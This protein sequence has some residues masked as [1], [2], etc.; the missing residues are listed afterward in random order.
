MKKA[1]NEFFLCSYHPSLQK[2]N[3]IHFTHREIDVLA[4]LVSARQ[5]KVIASSLSVSLKT[6]DN[7][8]RNIRDKINCNATDGVITFCEN[9]GVDGLLRTHYVNL[10]N[11]VAFKQS[12][13]QIAAMH[14]REANISCTIICFQKQQLEDP[15]LLQLESHLKLAGITVSL[16]TQEPQ[17]TRPTH[18]N[19]FSLYII[20]KSFLAS[21][22]KMVVPQSNNKMLFLLPES[23]NLTETYKDLPYVSYHNL[24]EP[25]QYYELFFE[26]VRKIFPS[27]DWK[28]F[29]PQFKESNENGKIHLIPLISSSNLDKKKSAVKEKNEF[30]KFSILNNKIL[31]FSFFVTI[32]LICGAVFL[33]HFTDSQNQRSFIRS[34]L[35]IPVES[36]LL[37]RSKLMAQID[38]TLSN[39]QRGIKAIAIVGIGGAGK[40]TLAHQYA[41]KKNA[42]VIWKINA[43]TKESLKA[44]FEELAQHLARTEEY[45][46]TLR[47]IQDVKKTGEKE[48]KILLFVQD[49]LR[50]YPNWLLIY[51]NVEQFIDIQKYF[52]QDIKLWGE[53]KVILT[54]KNS[55]IQNN[56]LI[57]NV[58]HIGELSPEQK[59]NLFTKITVHGSSR[60]VTAIDSIELTEFLKNI[61]P[62]PLDISVAAY[63]LKSTPIT[64]KK[65]LENLENYNNEF[66]SVQENLLKEAGTYLKTRYGII[67]LSLEHLLQSYKDFT[68]LL[69]LI[70]LLD[71]QNI[72]AELLKEYKNDTIVDNFIYHLKKYSLITNAFFKPCSDGFFSVHRSTQVISLAYLIKKLHLKKGDERLKQLSNTLVNSTT[73]AIERDDFPK[74]ENLLIHY[75]AFLSHKN[76]FDTKSEAF[77]KCMLGSIY[78]YLYDLAKAKGILEEY[79][80]TL[81][82]NYK[83]QAQALICLGIVEKEAGHFEKAKHL[84][85][86]AIFIYENNISKYNISFART[87]VDLGEVYRLLDNVE[88]AKIFLE[89]GVSLY[90]NLYAN[91]VGLARGYRYL[92]LLHRTLGEYEKSK[93]LL[94]QSLQIYRKKY[95]NHHVGVA[96]VLAHLGIVYKELGDSEK[97]RNL[98]EE[99]LSIFK[100]LFS[101]H[102]AKVAWVSLH[103]GDAYKCLGQ[104]EKARNILEKSL[105]A[106]KNLY[107]KENNWIAR[108]SLKLGE[109]ENKLCNKEKARVLFESG[110]K[111]QQENNS[112]MNFQKIRYY[113]Q[114]GDFY[115]NLKNYEK[116]KLVYSQCLEIYDKKFNS[117]N[118][119]VSS[120]IFLKLGEVYKN[121][122]DYNKAEE[123][124][125]KV[126]VNY[127]KYYG[128]NH[129]RTGQIFVNLGNL[130]L[131]KGEL[132]LAESYLTKAVKIF[133]K[134]GTSDLYIIL[135][136]LSEVYQSKAEKMSKT[137]QQKQFNHLITQARDCLKQAI[138]NV[139]IYFPEGSPHIQRIQVKLQNLSS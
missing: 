70:S 47:E 72:S 18:Q 104:Y 52:P 75:Q 13:Q 16:G 134:Q 83:V 26:V 128:D 114:L 57:N 109:I 10:L 124:F 81:N 80:P 33:Y 55:N 118:P 25:Q 44:S 105:T 63:Y 1:K 56:S 68:E 90:K 133:K 12:L 123:V 110:L 89:R 78:C 11:R 87:L 88:E 96:Q 116:A 125:N 106:Y 45:K 27:N 49:Q 95:S 97:A 94:E 120:K 19:E 92:A 30:G 54:T 4:F 38:Q 43:E 51:D 99:S 64:Y 59:F 41:C 65:Y 6:I 119:R 102:H 112:T 122:G 131:C 22:K 86:Q 101:R 23:E 48:E 74:L 53:G 113:H 2:I 135:E 67:T 76:L 58:I 61:P 77:I 139:K 115:Y 9:F 5:H 108:V 40:T 100:T 103:L 3:G 136:D 39:N 31:V 37:D 69:L 93:N 127:K 20:P 46:K 126:L 82:E 130:Y 34:D 42:Q 91:E 35:N 62:F 132:N 98:L 50:L 8:T 15:F 84:L 36:I 32:F 137:H 28:C 17:L 71:S 79:L 7:H 73:S 107:Q 24:S 60:S 111:I 129:L 14:H 117:Y 85:K 29:I 21:E 66:A 138:D 121:L